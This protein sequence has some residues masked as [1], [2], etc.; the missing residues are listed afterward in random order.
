MAHQQPKGVD[1]TV[2]G[3]MAEV[4]SMVITEREREAREMRE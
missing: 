1:F 3:E 4:T 2:V